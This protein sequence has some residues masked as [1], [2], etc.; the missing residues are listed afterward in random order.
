M[1]ATR[2]VPG[3][4]EER[5]G[6]LARLRSAADSVVSVYLNTRWADEHQRER[7]RI[8][9]KN[10]LTRM[11][12][13]PAGP[14]DGGD[15]DWVEREGHAVIEQGRFADAQGVAL[16]ACRP[17]GLRETIPVHMPFEDAFVVATTPFLRPL[18]LAAEAAP[19]ALVVFVDAESARF[20]PLTAAGI[21]EEVR[22]E[23]EVPGHHRRG[24][25]AQMAQTRYQLH[26]HEHRRRHFEAVAKTLTELVKQHGVR[27]LV[28]A[29]EPR[30]IAVFRKHLPAALDAAVAGTVAGARFESPAVIADRAIELVR[31][32]EGARVAAEVDSALTEA[33]KHGRAVAGLEPTLG[34]LA[35]GAVH[36]LY[37][38]EG[39]KRPGRRCVGCAAIDT[40]EDTTCRLCGNTLREVELGEAMSERVIREGGTVFPVQIHAGLERMD[41]V[42]AVLRFPL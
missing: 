34:A 1:M 37:L 24:G 11:R 5:L 20:V 31:Q 16:F 29:G 25:W 14:V 8:F 32:L 28:M 3:G 42:A 19:G 10:E 7:A 33:A 39:L 30:A 18:T 40:G 23:S 38:L 2:S 26:V 9:L 22:L 36:R 15:L 12:R 17:L 27:R 4:L 13:A 6:G 21:G 41:G 35:R